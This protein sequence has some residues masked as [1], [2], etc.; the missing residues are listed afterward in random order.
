MLDIPARINRQRVFFWS[1]KT[2]KVSFRLEALQKL[3]RVIVANEQ[4]ICTALAEDLGK[5]EL[6][7]VVSEIALVTREIDFVCSRL[8]RWAKPQR[9]RTSLLN[10]PAK[11][12]VRYEPLGVALIIGP[13]NYPFQLVFSPL[14][15]ALAAGNCALLKPSE[16]TMQTTAVVCRIIAETFDPD[17]VSVMP[18]GPDLVQT[19]LEEQFDIVFFT[20]S[21]RVGRL[22]M[23]AAA[24]HPTPV[25]LE[26]GGKSPAIVDADADLAMAARRIVWGKFFNAGQTCVAP[27]Y[28]LVHD[29]VKQALLDRMTARISECYGPEPQ[30][31]HDYA[32]IVN[33]AH[34]DRLAAYLADGTIVAGGDLDRATR[35]MAPTIL[36]GVSWQ[37]PVMQ[38][39]IF[40]P[41][42]PVLGFNNHDDILELISRHPAPLALYY[43]TRD[44]AKQRRVMTAAAFGGG[45]VNDTIIHL[46]EHRLPFGG[47][48]ASGLGRYHGQASFA[49]FS[50]CKSVL[51]R[52]TWFD[53]PLRYP[54]YA[55][56]LKLLKT[57]FKWF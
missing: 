57:L 12:S 23:Q 40:G 11:G 39:E 16:L 52:G 27:D 30:H 18:G 2:R 50:H 46:T 49:A 38:D 8:R 35:Y 45:C 41:I 47:V 1:G 6:E 7:A 37:S 21:T 10:A 42:L 17:Y 22:V 20:G 31:S 5:P 55:G 24:R 4:E 48:G 43:F 53:L 13:W 28:L 14:V 34:F 26:L 19:L 51:E 33:T 56:K 32:R 44:A 54:P 3:K 9:V 15:G 36:D 29:D 25:I